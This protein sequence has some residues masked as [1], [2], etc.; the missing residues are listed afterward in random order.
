LELAI[1]KPKRVIIGPIVLALFL[2]FFI[3][4]AIYNL[5]HAQAI[6]PSSLWLL[7]VGSMLFGFCKE[8]G[9]KQVAINVLGAFSIKE[10]IQ[11][12]PR[13]DGLN[14]I[15]FGYRFLMFRFLYLTVPVNKIESVEWSPGQFSCRMGKDMNDWLVSVWYDHDDPVKSQLQ[16]KLRHPDQ[17][18]YI[19]GLGGPKAEINIFG[20]SV[21]DLLRHSGASLVQGAS[22]CIYVRPDFQG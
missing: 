18:I 20:R 12:V 4:L 3:A 10:S 21:L 7:L 14:E 15:Q 13:K 2:V 5:F 6:I 16:S 1:P 22:D 17:E 8:L 19:I 9:V 11:T